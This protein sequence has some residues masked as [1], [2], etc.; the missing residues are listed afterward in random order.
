[1][2]FSAVVTHAAAA[3]CGCGATFLVLHVP[4]IS[5]RSDNDKK[6]LGDATSKSVSPIDSSS[7][8]ENFTHSHTTGTPGTPASVGSH[9]NSVSAAA[10]LMPV[11]VFR[12]HPDMEVAFDA[13][14]RNPLYSLERLPPQHERVASEH[15]QSSDVGSVST[16][17][18]GT[19]KTRQGMNFY[20]EKSLPPSHRSRNSYYKH[21]GYDRGHL[22][23]AS[24]FRGD[25]DAVSVT[26]NLCNVSPQEPTFNRRVWGRLEALIRTMAREEWDGGGNSTSR[27]DRNSRRRS[28]TYVVTGPI[29]L[30]SSVVVEED[31]SSSTSSSGT[32]KASGNAVHVRVGQ[33]S[34]KPWYQFSHVAIGQPPSLVHVPTHFF[35]MV[36]VV[37]DDN[38]RIEKIA[39]F[40]IPNHDASE[41]GG[42]DLQRFL[43]RISDVEAVTGMT[44]FPKYLGAKKGDEDESFGG[45]SSDEVDLRSIADALTDDVRGGGS[46][47]TSTDIVPFTHS[48]SATAVKK[49]RKLLSQALDVSLRHLCEGK[50]CSIA[51]KGSK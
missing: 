6:L 24:D 50:R 42:V 7:V 51:V 28:S 1:M 8:N 45:T 33:Q 27:S 12:P 32:S 41:R 44:F 3:V 19:G 15:R 4:F 30:P 2:G 37:N 31:T 43:V 39:A 17:A 49:K 29:W 26:F 9:G 48:T 35:K 34:K 22:I 40:V 14:T 21:T 10:P 47:S 46:S 11:T 38:E 36:A 23:P 13:R 20:E 5:S 16:T 25:A 18:A